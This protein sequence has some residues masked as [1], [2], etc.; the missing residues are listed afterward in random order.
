M[1]RGVRLL[2]AVSVLF[3][4]WHTVPLRTFVRLP[5]RQGLPSQRSKGRLQMNAEVG[6]GITTGDLALG[7]LFLAFCGAY[8]PQAL[9]LNGAAWQVGPFRYYTNRGHE[10]FSEAVHRGPKEDAIFSY[11]DTFGGVQMPALSSNNECIL[12]LIDRD[13]TNIYDHKR[14]LEERLRE[15][16]CDGPFAKTYFNVEEALEATEGSESA[17]FFAKLPEQSGGRGIRVLQREDLTKDL[18]SDYVFQRAVQD[19]ELLDGRKFVIRYFFWVYQ[20]CLYLHDHGVVI[21]HGADYDPNS[22][23]EAVQVRHDWYDSD[24]ETYLITLQSSDQAP[25][26]RRAIAE[27][28]QELAPALAPLL[29][30]SGDKGRY[31]L[32]GGDALMQR[33]GEAKL[34]E[35]NM[36]PNLCSQQA[37]VDKGVFLPVL[38]DM[39]AFM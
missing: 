26:W 2:T 14:G 8:L 11:F 27:R 24:S 21:V 37:V 12:Q 36:Y 16:D 5:P 19:L 3:I 28:L 31:A 17:L 25:R 38:E 20:G 29:Q 7:G 1:T 30:A 15:F 23:S 10:A 6:G 4:A 32:V 34:I 18:S 39:M 13:V 33:N 22:V 9:G 35:L